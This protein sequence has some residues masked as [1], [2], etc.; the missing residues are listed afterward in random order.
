[1]CEAMLLWFPNMEAPLTSVILFYR[2]I[3]KLV[4]V[5]PSPLTIPIVESVFRHVMLLEQ[6]DFKLSTH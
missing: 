2:N 6:R 4:I 3:L 5:Q 1:M